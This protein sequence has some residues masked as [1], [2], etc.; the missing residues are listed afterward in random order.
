VLEVSGGVPVEEE[1]AVTAHELWYRQSPWAVGDDGDNSITQF[2]VLGLWSANR[3]RLKIAPEVWRRCLE[4]T[5][6]VQCAD[7]GW[8]YSGSGSEGYGSMTC[9]GVCTLAICLE[10]LGGKPL[11]DLQIQQG[12]RWLIENKWDFEDNLKHKNSHHYY[13][14]YSI[15]RLGRILGIDFIGEKEWYPLGAR[16]LVDNQKK[17]GSW[18]SKA[19][20]EVLS[21]CFAL[22]FL[23]RATPSFKPKPKPKDG[24]GT[25]LATASM[26]MG[27]R[28]YIILDASGSMLGRMGGKSKFDI[29]RGAVSEL[30]GRLDAESHVALRVYGNR[31]RAIDLEG[32]L[33]ARA[34]TDST[35]EIPM[36]K[37]DTAAFA[38][39]LK[40]LRARGKTPLAHSLDCTIADMGKLGASE[41][42]P[43][44]VILLTDGGEDTIP[45]R[46]P[47]EPAGKLAKMSGVN[48]NIVGFDIGRKDWQEQLTAMSR[49]AG[50]PYWSA[51]KPEMLSAQLQS[52]AVKAPPGFKVLDKGGKEV[53]AGQFGKPLKLRQGKYLFQ[54]EWKGRPARAEFW[55]NTDGTTRIVLNVNELERLIR[56][57]K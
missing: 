16:Y 36:R 2:A 52:A 42:E 55:V 31:Q 27:A 4:S 3:S 38:D 13:Y 12:L 46:N 19:E 30:I 15:E 50:T 5:R 11:E 21:T 18:V 7:G 49:A 6:R 43:V 1:G 41:E 20:S 34:N 32:Q 48:L 37:L 44:H 53:A 22:L 56:E 33:N 54:T 57:G 47:V 29:A 23:T 45:R 24:D 14:V 51:S 9:A 25:L 40:S 17:S 35:L 28:Y 8:A 26:P 10:H 39:K